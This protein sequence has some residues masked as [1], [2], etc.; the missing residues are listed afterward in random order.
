LVILDSMMPGI[1]GEAVATALRITNGVPIL[2]I[3]G[4]GD[5]ANQG[6]RLGGYGYLQKP[7]GLAEL[8][9]KVREGLVQSR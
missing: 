4:R 2:V 7:F 1:D 3:T 9:Q 5:A 8:V 6:Q